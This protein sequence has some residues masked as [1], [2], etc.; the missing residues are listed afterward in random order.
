MRNYRYNMK[1]L[2]KAS[3]LLFWAIGALAA[4][5]F[6]YLLFNP[7]IVLFAGLGIHY[8]HPVFANHSAWTHFFAGHF[9]DT[10][11]CV[12]L[13]LVTDFLSVNKYVTATDKFLLLSLPFLA[14]FGQ[15]AGIVP[16]TFDWLDIATYLAVILVYN[17]FSSLNLI[18]F[19]MKKLKSHLAAAVAAAAFLFMVFAS[20]PQNRYAYRKPQKMPCVRHDGLN[21]SPVLVQINID[22]SYT[23]KDLPTAQVSWQS[24]FMSKLLA[25]NSYKYKLA[26]GV[27]PNLTIN[28]T[29]NTDGY[30][31]YGAT[32][33]F[34]VYDD[35][36]WFTTQSNYVE[37]ALLF[38]DIATRMDR[39]VSNG[40]THDCP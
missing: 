35:N 2:Y 40:W 11:W 16:G 4:G 1:L 27:T 37:P 12:A 24:Y 21:Y 14:E 6:N 33:K 7:H 3:F 19:R 15:Y 8:A 18:P 20:A 26:Q 30:Q 39:Y 10:L 25:A 36:T 29:I 17:Y 5:V 28:I 22:G 34:Y 13:C 31:H 23:M 32:V 38:D 9:S